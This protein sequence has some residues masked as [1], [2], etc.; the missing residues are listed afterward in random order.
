VV[1]VVWSLVVR[2]VLGRALVGGGGVR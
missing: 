2:T 1:V